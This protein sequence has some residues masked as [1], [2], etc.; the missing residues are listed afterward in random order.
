MIYN[1]A[2]GDAIAPEFAKIGLEGETVVFRECLVVGPIDAPTPPEF[3][4]ERSHYILAEDPI[5]FHEKVADEIE[6]LRDAGP[7]DE[8]NLWFEYELFCSVNL[9]FS[10]D[11]LRGSG[12]KIYR[13]EPIVLS[14]DDRWNGFGKLQSGELRECYAS[15]RLLKDADLALASDLWMAYQNRDG[16]RLVE[17]SASEAPNFPY[18]SDVCAAAAEVET[19][20]ESI[21]RDII[22]SGITEFED[23]FAEFSRRAGVYGFG[24]LQIRE[25]LARIGT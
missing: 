25:L 6:K 8:V 21:V 20:P 5:E 15:R 19:L 24:D 3:W 9:W 18:L 10:I 14:K 11:M 12:A 23:I 13:V 17:L 1:V 2:P 4:D 7:G 16:K 22:S